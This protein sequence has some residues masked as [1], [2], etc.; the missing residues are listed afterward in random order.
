MARELAELKDQVE[1]YTKAN[2]YAL[3]ENFKLKERIRELEAKVQLFES[4]P[5]QHQQQSRLPS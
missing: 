4:A 1:G 3:V 5:Q 2:R